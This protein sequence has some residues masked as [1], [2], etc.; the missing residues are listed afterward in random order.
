MGRTNGTILQIS[1]KLVPGPR[2]KARRKSLRRLDSNQRPPE[3]HAGSLEGGYLGKCG[4]FGL[5]QKRAGITA[6]TDEPGERSEETYCQTVGVGTVPDR[7]RLSRR[8]R[9]RGHLATKPRTRPQAPRRM[10]LGV[11]T[12]VAKKVGHYT[13]SWPPWG[14]QIRSGVP[15]GK[16]EPNEAWPLFWCALVL[17]TIEP[18]RS[19]ASCDF[20]SF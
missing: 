3:P 1:C 14:T 9:H 2:E 16:S 10:A 8:P 7:P 12:L 4:P 20:L 15:R 5:V 17:R 6:G 13:P 11:S 19:F 18:G